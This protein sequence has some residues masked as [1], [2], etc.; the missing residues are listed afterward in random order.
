M[1]PYDILIVGGG[2]AGSS[3]AYCLRDSG[4][5]IGIL[6][7][8][9]FPRQKVCAGWVTPEVMRVLN[10]D[11]EDYAK[12]R[13]LQA[14]NGFKI[15]Q[16]GQRQIES[17]YPDEPV[18]YGIR[19]I[20]F[21]QYL[22]QRC[23]ASVLPPQACKLI[24]KT[25]DGWLINDS[26]QTKL[27]VGAGGHYCPVARTIGS[28][29]TGE[30]AVVAQEAEFLMSEEQKQNCSIQPQVPELFFT[31]DLKGYG[32]VFR[33]GDYLNIGLGREDKNK[34]PGHVKSFC[35]Y[36]AKLGKIPGDV[37]AN[38]DGHAYLLY[39]HAE[40]QLIAECALLIG[41]SAGLAY[42][43]SGEGIRPA[44]ESAILAADTIVNCANDYTQANLQAYNQ[45][46]QQRFGKRQTEP[47]LMERLPTWMKKTLASQLM[48]THWFTKNI[49][50]DKWFLQSH[51]VPMP[52][53]K[54]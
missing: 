1:Q 25:G 17:I 41:D 16:L 50:T 2:P 53:I 44:V 3:L 42:P 27:L 43:Q 47:G 11:L 10:I 35:E 7:K 32:W 30:L 51:Q 45:A 48:K 52:A 18:S 26:L 23:E 22:L 14:I 29:K 24:K 6:D 54:K 8:Q 40:R 20:E 37:A 5:K 4:L 19:R 21:D 9:S 28:K 13:V 36:L 15:S 46:M 49:V 33:K 31:P 12:G 38:Y 39:H 34:L